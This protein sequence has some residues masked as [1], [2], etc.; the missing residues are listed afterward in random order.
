MTRAPKW[1]FSRIG[2]AY[3]VARVGEEVL[4]R[5]RVAPLGLQVILPAEG[6][7]DAARVD[8]GRAGDDPCSI[9]RRRSE[10]T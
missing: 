4:G 3:L 10:S 9:A 5:A 2:L 1:T 8:D 7:D 6:R